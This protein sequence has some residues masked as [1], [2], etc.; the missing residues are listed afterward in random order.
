M[1][2]DLLLITKHE[3]YKIRVVRNE[4]V[5]CLFFLK[6]KLKYCFKLTNRLV[7]LQSHIRDSLSRIK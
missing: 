3:M 1:F 5:K 6:C 4:I 2:T 7:N